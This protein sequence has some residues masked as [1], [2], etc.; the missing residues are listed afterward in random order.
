MWRVNCT[1]KLKMG[2]WRVCNKKKGNLYMCIGS[3]SQ[4]QPVSE[5]EKEAWAII[6]P[7]LAALAVE[8][9]QH[10]QNG[11]EYY[12]KIGVLLNRGLGD[13]A[14]RLA[15]G[16]NILLNAAITLGRHQSDVN[17]ARWLARLFTSVADFLQQRPDLNT[18]TAFK[19]ALPTLKGREAPKETR[20][21]K[22][23]TAAAKLAGAVKSVSGLTKKLSQIS[24]LGE[25]KL[26][27][28][29]TKLR[30][31]VKVLCECLGLIVA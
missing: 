18:W 25:K 2:L 28:P 19:K 15:Y 22:K 12:Y 4:M 31:K 30:E 29:V 5:E 8:G 24:N 16:G 3:Q 10:D 11:F 27:K 20:T 23:P 26:V 9:R 1:S 6:N 21:S 14:K 13:P 7:E 17:R